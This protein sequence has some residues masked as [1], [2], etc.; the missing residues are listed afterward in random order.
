MSGFVKIC[1]M[2]DIRAVE[3]A[4]DSGADAIGFVFARSVRNV[5]PEQAADL[6]RPARGRVLCVAVTQH[7]STELLEHVFEV[8]GPDVLQT[9]REDFSRIS[10]PAGVEGWPVLRGRQSTEITATLAGS[11]RA[12]FE[13]QRSG[14]GAVSDWDAATALAGR[15]K[16]IL[17]G[18]LS[19]ANVQQ[20]IGAV[21]PYGVDVSSGV[22][23]APGRKSAGLIDS[24]VSGARA[25]FARVQGGEH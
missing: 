5:T 25:A 20:A 21:H 24:F 11:Q 10:L 12:L 13:G 17:A 9:D 22:E 16:L 6:A 8:F 1:G 7:P 23:E 4:L 15:C 19:P 3:A 18:G 14:A 2:N